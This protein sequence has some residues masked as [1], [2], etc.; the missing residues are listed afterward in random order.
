MDLSSR[1]TILGAAIGGVFAIVAAVI[2]A[3]IALPPSG[4][5]GGEGQAGQPTSAPP[6]GNAPTS[7]AQPTQ[8]TPGPAPT[9]MLPLPN[10]YL[11]AHGTMVLNDPLTRANNKWGNDHS[12]TGTCE[13]KVDGM[14]VGSNQKYHECYGRT[15]VRDFT[16]EVQFNLSYARAAGIFFRQSGPGQWYAMNIGRSGKVWI[17]RAGAEIGTVTVGPF[18]PTAWQT[19]AVT[20]VGSTL[21][22]YVNGKQ[23]LTVSDSTYASGPIGL[24]TDGGQ[25]PNGEDP[26]GVTIFRNARVWQ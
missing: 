14:Y 6:T 13:F 11:P 2:A 7:T 3:L 10:P 19:F 1:N 23:V 16:Y 24:I 5:K 9:S 4:G 26:N 8:T 18:D 21:T 15:S 25:P 22:V 17:D 20:G 12:D